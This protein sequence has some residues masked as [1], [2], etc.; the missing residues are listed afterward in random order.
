MEQASDDDL[1]QVPY[2]VQYVNFERVKA[3][4]VDRIVKLFIEWAKANPASAKIALDT[5]QAEAEKLGLAGR[6]VKVTEAHWEEWL[7]YLGSR[8]ETG[9]LNYK[10]GRAHRI[11]LK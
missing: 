6:A 9:T 4:D 7:A 2:F 5:I 11:Y 3:L 1:A 8:R 10:Q